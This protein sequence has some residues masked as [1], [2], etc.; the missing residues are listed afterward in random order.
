MKS[1]I[2]FITSA[3]LSIAFAAEEEVDSL[4]CGRDNGRNIRLADYN[5]DFLPA[6][7]GW[8]NDLDEFRGAGYVAGT[9]SAADW[10]LMEEAAPGARIFCENVAPVINEIGS[11]FFSYIDTDDEEVNAG[12]AS[13]MWVGTPN[14][15]RGTVLEKL[16][17]VQ[18]AMSPQDPA[19]IDYMKTQS[20]YYAQLK[21]MSTAGS[22]RDIFAAEKF[23]PGVVEYN[24]KLE[25]FQDAV[26]D[27]QAQVQDLLA[28]S[29]AKRPSKTLANDQRRKGTAV[30]M[31]DVNYD[32]SA[33]FLLET[34]KEG[35]GAGVR[36]VLHQVRKDVA[37]AAKDL[38]EA[39]QV[40]KRNAIRY[41]KLNQIS[42]EDERLESFKNRVREASYGLL[43]NCLVN[44]QI[45]NEID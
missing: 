37:A 6:S 9:G 40:I 13:L 10:D 42:N 16:N 14:D 44:Y 27:K 15:W 39:A 30:S 25:I 7:Q 11:D 45:S 38:E 21:R 43:R 35:E 32:Q 5:H 12:Q 18:C 19:L 41:S 29:R 1:K 20:Y 24:K 2:I 34:K 36:G 23:G 33:E 22:E 28:Q 8:A 31:E 17:A 26:K 4:K 3:I